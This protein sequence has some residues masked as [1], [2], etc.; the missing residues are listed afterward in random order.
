[1]KEKI[2]VRFVLENE[3]GYD[4]IVSIKMD[5]KFI[6]RVGEKVL[7][8]NTR[9]FKKALFDKENRVLHCDGIY[10]NGEDELTV[11]KIIHNYTEENHGIYVVLVYNYEQ[12]L[13]NEDEERGAISRSDYYKMSEQLKQERK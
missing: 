5:V 7:I 11:C 13:K 3:Y 10:L 1:M 6:P 9:L 12:Y 2:K 8:D 4:H